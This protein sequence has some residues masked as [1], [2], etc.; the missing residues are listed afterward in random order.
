MGMDRDIV[1]YTDLAQGSETLVYS[2][3]MD[4]FVIERWVSKEQALEWIK[5][6]A[7]FLGKDF[8]HAIQ[9]TSSLGNSGVILDAEDKMFSIESGPI[10]SNI[11]P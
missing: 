4:A 2:R 6:N 1:T 7:E 9:K 5:N 10:L 8:D 3:S 11:G